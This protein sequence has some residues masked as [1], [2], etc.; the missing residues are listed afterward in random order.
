M[1]AQI[2]ADPV[3]SG[4]TSTSTT[5]IWN[6]FCYIFAT[7]EATEE[8]LYDQFV[9]E[10]ETLVANGAPATANWIQSQA[11]NFQYS[12]STPQIP[13]LST[14]TFAPYW[15]VV[16]PSLRIIT[17]CSVTTNVLG[18]VNVLVAT[19]E[20]TPAPLTA[21][22]LNAFQAFL[23]YVG[24]AGIVYNAVSLYPDLISTAATVYY[25]GSY[26]AVIQANLLAA[27]T[28]L[29]ASIPFSGVLKMS[30]IETALL[31]VTG[32]N[33]V[34][35]NN[36][37]ARPAS[38]AFGSGSNLIVGNQELSRLWTTIAGYIIDE[39]TSGNTF[40]DLLT[41]VAQ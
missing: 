25:N 12:S 17:N 5:A 4:L 8:Q 2:Q 26:S 37:S 32:V 20:P 34:V 9:T 1:E 10:V 6:L 31:N 35:L 19:G 16:N 40:T 24:T 30:Q 14:T 15:P 7:S 41:L 21:P 36:V 38:I 27:Y 13:Q 11:F 29:L 39:T 28:S 3:L 33:D 23:N 18:G 22:Q